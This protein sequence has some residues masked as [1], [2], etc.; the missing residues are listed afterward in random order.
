MVG[1]AEIVMKVSKY[2]NLRCSYCYELSELNQKH[3]MSL[4]LIERIF[5]NVRSSLDDGASVDFIWHGGEPLL[6]PLEYYSAIQNLQRR[7][8]GTTPVTNALQTNL[9]VL[10]PKH[11]DFFRSKHFFSSISVSCDVYG[12]LRVDLLGHDSTPKVLKNIETLRSE[13]IQVG[14]ITVLTRN[15]LP[16]VQEIFGFYDALNMQS[17]FLPFYRHD[18]DEQRATHAISFKEYLDALLRLFDAWLRSQSAPPVHPIT[19]Y[20]QYAAMH[21][22]SGNTSASTTN[23]GVV[24]IVDTDGMTWGQE[25]A[26]LEGYSYGNLSRQPLAGLLA[27]SARRADLDRA[28]RNVET[29]CH[30]CSYRGSCPGDFAAGITVDQQSELDRFGCP[31]RPFLDRVVS[32]FSDRYSRAG[33]INE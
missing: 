11:L 27:S 30:G 4:D 33:P 10:A 5:R 12:T 32:E 16:Y 17:R 13:G 29:H 26:Y 19:D 20:I 21:L 1:S 3:R 7:I 8:F 18:N 6:V 22:N 24:L 23:D 2:C 14:A 25:S 9:T 28:Q 31:V 15:T